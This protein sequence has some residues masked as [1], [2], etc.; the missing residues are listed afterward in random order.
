MINLHLYKSI[1]KNLK[2]K[3]QYIG[4]TFNKDKIHKIILTKDQNS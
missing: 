1:F 3:L 4:R 2:V